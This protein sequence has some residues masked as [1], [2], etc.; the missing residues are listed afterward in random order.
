MAQVDEKIRWKRLPGGEDCQPFEEDGDDNKN[1]KTWIDS[2]NVYP[3]A[4]DKVNN[5]RN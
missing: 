4:E 1:S 3:K 2:K 5:A